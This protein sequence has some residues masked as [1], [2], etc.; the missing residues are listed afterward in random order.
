MALGPGSGSRARAAPEDPVTRRA[1]APV[2]TP[3]RRLR[4]RRAAAGP[5][6]VAGEAVHAINNALGVL[7]AAEYLL[8]RD[9]GSHSAE[10]LAALVES[11][12]QLTRCTNA[13]SLLSQRAADLRVPR[14]SAA[15][16]LPEILGR[17]CTDARLPLRWRTRPSAA[18]E[19]AVDHELLRWLVS[20]A[21]FSLGRGTSRDGAIAAAL[22]AARGS[23]ELSLEATGTAAAAVGARPNLPEL[24]LRG[25]RALLAAAGVRVSMRLTPTG[26]SVKLSLPLATK[27]QASG[28][29]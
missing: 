8:G 27:A 19:L 28:E 23:L 10:A 1:K 7:F 3:T 6:D 5:A 22:R 16:E 14:R 25:R 12:T 9:A 18:G 21:L 4:N 13:L 15:S 24:A 20:C 11:T 17:F 26:R 2:P 29:R